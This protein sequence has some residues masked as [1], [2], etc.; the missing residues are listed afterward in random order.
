MLAASGFGV[1]DVYYLYV[2]RLLLEEIP[3]YR[4]LATHRGSKYWQKLV[5][6]VFDNRDGHMVLFI[7]QKL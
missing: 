5:T 4:W 3:L 7:A 6:N 2:H 1:S